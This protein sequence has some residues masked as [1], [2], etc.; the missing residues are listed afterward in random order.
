MKDFICRMPEEVHEKLREL[1]YHFNISMS[2][3]V[4][5]ILDDYCKKQPESIIQKAVENKS[6]K[7]TR[8]SKHALEFSLLALTEPLLKKIWDNPEDD[9]YNDI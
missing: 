5:S 6:Q 2:E 4:R 1:S 8:K 7:K 9:V 3:I